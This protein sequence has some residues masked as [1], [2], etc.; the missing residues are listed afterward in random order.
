MLPRFNFSIRVERKWR[1]R[2]PRPEFTRHSN[3]AYVATR[4]QRESHSRSRPSQFL[5]GIGRY[6]TLRLNTELTVLIGADRDGFLDESSGEETR[7]EEKERS[8]TENYFRAI[9]P[10]TIEAKVVVV[11]RSRISSQ[12]EEDTNNARQIP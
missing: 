6:E 12:A 3:C 10:R 2:I 4:P 8:W 1:A 9:S 7:E 5:G 11:V